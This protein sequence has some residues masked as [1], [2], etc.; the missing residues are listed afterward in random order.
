MKQI[1]KLNKVNCNISYQRI[2][3][4]RRLYSIIYPQ[5][6]LSSL[7]IRTSTLEMGYKHKVIKES[8]FLE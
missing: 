3:K 2:L 6:N 1:N 5:T 8:F 4:Y 7:N